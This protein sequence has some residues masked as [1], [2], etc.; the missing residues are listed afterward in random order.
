MK[1]FREMRVTA[2]QRLKATSKRLFHEED[3]DRKERNVEEKT[4]TD[5]MTA[6]FTNAGSA[7]I[8]HLCQ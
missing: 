7:R 1:K 3:E 4:M 2:T 8:S 5:V 6:T